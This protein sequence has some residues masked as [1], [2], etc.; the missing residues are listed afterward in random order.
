MFDAVSLRVFVT[1]KLYSYV[2]W[3]WVFVDLGL[4]DKLDSARQMPSASQFM[5]LWI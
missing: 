1:E 4:A 5:M 3:N 2:I